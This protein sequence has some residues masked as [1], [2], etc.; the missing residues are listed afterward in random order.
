MNQMLIDD[1]LKNRRL[2]KD[3]SNAD[4]AR[5]IWSKTAKDLATSKHLMP[6]DAD[7]A[8]ERAYDA[9]F[10]GVVAILRAIGYRLGH[11]YQRQ[12]AVEVLRA[13]LDDASHEP[14]V[15]SF[16]DMRYKR[17]RVSYDAGEATETEAQQAVEDAEKLVEL[18][19][20]VFETAAA[21][22]SGA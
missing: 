16:D 11:Q 3:K 8:H 21:G 12:T 22:S 1:L 18:L 7:R 4:I 20:P 19:K 15:E 2:R 14:L 10:K 13:F 6:V 9:A 5:Q 17:N